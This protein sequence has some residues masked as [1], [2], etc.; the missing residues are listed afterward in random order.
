MIPTWPA[1]KAGEAMQALAGRSGLDPGSVRLPRAP[2]TL[3]LGGAERIAPWIEAMADT[4]GLE[5]E[6][7]DISYAGL[8]DALQSAGPALLRLPD[9]SFLALLGGSALLCTDLSIRRVRRKA[10]REAICRDVEAPH[11]AEI[12]ELLTYANIRPWR[13][14][15]VLA[16]I[17]RDRLGPVSIACCWRL[18]MEARKSFLQHARRAGVPGRVSMLI[19]AHVL[20]YALWILSWWLIGQGALEGRLDWGWLLAWALL[21]VTTIPLRALTTW[22]QGMV[23]ITAGG[24][25]R[26]RLLF[27]ALRLD[28][29]QIRRQGAGQLLG[30]VIESE[31]LESLALSGGFL[32]FVAGVEL[33]MAAVVLSLGAGGWLAAIA[34]L[35]WT[36]VTFLIA[37]RYFKSNRSWTA[38]RLSMT[39]DLIERMAGH[40]TRL[41][42]EPA[43][44]W[45]DGEDQE[46]AR[47]LE[48]SIGLDRRTVPLAALVP[49]GWLILGILGLAPAFVTGAGSTAGLAIG[50]GGILLA[51]RALKGLSAG[52]WNLVGAA[53]AWKQVEQLFLAA[54]RPVSRGAFVSPAAGAENETLIDAQDITFRYHARGGPVLTGCNLR[55]ANGERVLLDGPSGGGKSTLGSLL[56][57]LRVPESGLLLAGGLDRNTLGPDGWRQVVAS[58]P[59]F[60]ENHVLCGPFA[61]NA[62]M[63]RRGPLGAKDVEEAE[64]V[65]RELGL[66]DLLERMPAGLMQMVGETGWQLSHGERSRLYIARTLLQRAEMIVLDESFAALDPEN[67]R[68]ALAC[69]LKRGRTVLAI[70]HR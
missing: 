51:Y 41:A 59:Q 13:R 58:A 26:E 40:R 25:L 32:A 66:G 7:A 3:E 35:A 30:R 69:V 16:D 18:R 33:V 61:F 23:A 1:A 20:E 56:A 10:V 39:H 65:C 17:L 48:S 67:L 53:I 15:R 68:L 70:A 45:H 46:L 43:A 11:L 49:R 22:L 8:D 5:A 29:D 36:A 54:A 55:I 38:E 44:R 27:G 34:L 63:G 52:L 62:L 42:Q 57:G 6:R 9:G 21:L 60:H 28:P 64:T 14:K 47:Y 37:W 2:E 24:L 19:G 50:I 12:S 4:L 31:A